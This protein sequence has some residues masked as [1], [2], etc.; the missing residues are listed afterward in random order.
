M[1][2]DE[3]YIDTT[4]IVWKVRGIIQD[5]ISKE[6]YIKDWNEYKNN[7]LNN[8]S[9]INFNTEIENYIT[10]GKALHV[11]K[12]EMKELLYNCI[13]LNNNIFVETTRYGIYS[14]KEEIDIKQQD[15]NNFIDV[16]IG[17]LVKKQQL[18]PKR[19]YKI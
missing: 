5:N 18:I 3:I 19:N 8:L 7:I 13:V 1:F 14:F 12:K 6:S 15:I 16:C 11:T 10:Y 9:N 2:I 17:I 4:R